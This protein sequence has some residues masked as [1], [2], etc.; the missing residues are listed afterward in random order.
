V[1]AIR[2]LYPNVVKRLPRQTLVK[3][4]QGRGV[5]L[6]WPNHRQAAE[7]IGCG[8][9][10]GRWSGLEWGSSIQRNLQIIIAE[11]CR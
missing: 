8:N 9:A 2:T 3:D 4:D 6:R 1:L 11:K 7:Q 10:A 5:H